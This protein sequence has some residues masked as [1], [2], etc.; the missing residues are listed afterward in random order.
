MLFLLYL[1]KKTRC[2]S[3]LLSNLFS[4]VINTGYLASPALP[5]SNLYLSEGKPSNLDRIPTKLLCIPLICH[6]SLIYNPY[7]ASHWFFVVQQLVHASA[8]TDRT[9]LKCVHSEDHAAGVKLHHKRRSVKRDKQ[10]NFLK[11]NDSFAK[12]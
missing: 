2:Y 6:Y 8:G 4:I 3:H 9:I 1:K 7:A 5:P 12:T 11:R 10:C